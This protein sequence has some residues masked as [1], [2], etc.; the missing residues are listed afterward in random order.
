M[1]NAPLSQSMQYIRFDVQKNNR[2]LSALSE[3]CR[4]VIHLAVLTGLRIGELLALRCKRVDL[5]RA[6][7]EVAGT[8]SDGEFG[9]PKTRNSNGTILIR[10]FFRALNVLEDQESGPSGQTN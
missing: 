5:L 1:N 7:I 2:L 10:G 8:Y 4:G 9:S 6:T 3:P